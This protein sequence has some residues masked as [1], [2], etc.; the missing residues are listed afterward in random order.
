MGLNCADATWQ[1]IDWQHILLI[2]NLLDYLMWDYI[3]DSV[4]KNP[5]QSLDVL[6]KAVSAEISVNYSY[7]F[8]H[9]WSLPTP[10][11]ESNR[12]HFESL[13]DEIVINVLICEEYIF[14]LSFIKLFYFGVIT[15]YLVGTYYRIIALPIQVIIKCPLI[16][17]NML[18][19]SRKKKIKRSSKTCCFS[20]KKTKFKQNFSCL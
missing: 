18:R 7:S 3:K 15:G 13:E 12:K 9:L 14:I 4:F 8:R 10:Y 11:I 19:I 5:P 16:F 1:K 17:I 20:R 6:Q 2:W